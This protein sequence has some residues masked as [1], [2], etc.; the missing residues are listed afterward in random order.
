MEIRANTISSPELHLMASQLQLEGADKAF[1]ALNR[2]SLQSKWRV[3]TLGAVCPTQ[4]GAGWRPCALLLA[5]GA[6]NEGTCLCATGATSWG[7]QRPAFI[8]L[9]HPREASRGAGAERGPGRLPPPQRRARL[10]V[11]ARRGLGAAREGEAPAR[12]CD[13]VKAA[14]APVTAPPLG[15]GSGSGSGASRRRPHLAAEPPASRP[16]AG[17]AWRGAWRE[18]VAERSGPR[19]RAAGRPLLALALGLALAA[20]ARADGDGRA[21]KDGESPGNF[22]EDE[23]WLSS[24]SQYSGKIK[25]WNRFRDVSAGG[26]SCPRPGETRGAEPRAAQRGGA[27]RQLPLP[28]PAGG[29]PGP[30]PGPGSRPPGRAQLPPVR[31][32]RRLPPAPRAA[33]GPACGGAHRAAARPC[34]CQDERA[35]DPWLQLRETESRLKPEM[36]PQNTTRIR[37]DV[38]LDGPFIARC[39][40]VWLPAMNWAV[41]GNLW[42]CRQELI[43]LPLRAVTPWCPAEVFWQ[44]PVRTLALQRIHLNYESSDTL[45]SGGC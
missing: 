16:R 19:M 25:H 21:G 43:S 26:A 40:L 2:A 22:M 7:R 10:P 11:P 14:A 29:L 38:S 3:L 31:R 15:A 28:A 30:G 1:L 44:A 36:Q 20:V 39:C 42:V 5:G 8:A 6:A 12:R 9:P 17:A 13:D 41:S 4:T 45:N 37:V 32:R 27:G 33:A 23:Q 34:S 35:A 18:R 24:I